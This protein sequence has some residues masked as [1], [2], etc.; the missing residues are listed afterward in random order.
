L[1]PPS[2]DFPGDA[3]GAVINAVNCRNL[4]A[5]GNTLYNLTTNYST[6]YGVRLRMNHVNAD[7][8][9]NDFQLVTER[10]IGFE[11]DVGH[12]QRATIFDNILSS[13]NSVH[14]K[15]HYLDSDAVFLIRNT[16]VDPSGNPSP[17]PLLDPSFAPVH[18][19][20]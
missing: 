2:P 4:L 16:Y 6:G 18:I 17:R 3:P 19:Q 5:A 9:R 8:F 12:L 20:Y 10:S 14:L 7:I 1:C 11:G 13:G 15:L